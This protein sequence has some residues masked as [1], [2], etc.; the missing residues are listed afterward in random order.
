MS[1]EAYK[2]CFSMPFEF[3][4]TTMTVAGIHDDGMIMPL[5]VV[6]NILSFDILYR[7][8]FLILAYLGQIIGKSIYLRLFAQTGSI[9]L[10]FLL[11][12]KNFNSLTRDASVLTKSLAL[13][14]QRS[15]SREMLHFPSR[16]QPSSLLVPISDIY[17][18]RNPFRIVYHFVLENWS[19]EKCITY[20]RKLIFTNAIPESLK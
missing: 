18:K 14:T 16:S 7:Y 8:F 10:Y 3:T 11:L 5:I 4:A 2:Y 1:H 19:V 13:T 6:V 15:Q 9:I 17:Y 20:C 12:L